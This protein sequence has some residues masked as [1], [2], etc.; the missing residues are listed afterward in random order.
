[1]P[2]TTA[3]SPNP[4]LPHVDVVAPPARE[5]EVDVLLGEAQLAGEHGKELFSLLLTLSS[6]AR[7]GPRMR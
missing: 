5:D 7:Y 4:D 2:T 6:I 3:I 1:M